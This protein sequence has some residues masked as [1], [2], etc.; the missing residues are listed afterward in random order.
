MMQLLTSKKR[1]CKT[2]STSSPSQ[3]M[4]VDPDKMHTIHDTDVKLAKASPAAE[5]VVEIVEGTSPTDGNTDNGE[6]VSEMGGS[7][8]I[9][10]R[11]HD[12]VAECCKHT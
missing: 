6:N 11:N 3:D 1:L 2:R 12:V 7:V 4:N 5:N 10:S 8:E 9:N